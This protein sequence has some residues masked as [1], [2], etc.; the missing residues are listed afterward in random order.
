MPPLYNHGHADSLSITLSVNGI[1]LLVDSGTYGYNGVSKFRKYFKG[2]QSHN[3]VTIDDQDQANQETGFI[4]SHPYATRIVENKSPYGAFLVEAEHDGYT[5]LAQP[6][7]HWRAVVQ[8]NDSAFIV[9]DRFHG[10]GLHK[11]EL[12]W[13]LHPDTE[14]KKKNGWWQVKH[15]DIV[16]FIKLMDGG[17]LDLL[18]GDI[19]PIKGWYSPQY[20]VRQT[21][22]VLTQTL[23]GEPAESEFISVMCA[24]QKT[25]AE[26]I[27]AALCRVR[28]AAKSCKGGK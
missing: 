17:N 15:S 26:Q 18:Q 24:G 3:T 19:N 9:Q 4:W 8:I 20:G 2:T 25:D 28:L 1:L 13:H 12:N 16:L 21:C 7:V 27:E 11:Y 22:S 6:V 23:N 14:V 10:H 5:R